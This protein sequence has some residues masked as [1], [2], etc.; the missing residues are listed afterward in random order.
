MINLGMILGRVGRLDAR[1]LGNGTKVV[2]L[3]LVTSKKLGKQSEKEEKI[4][5]HNVTLYNR[6]AEIVEAYVQ[7]GDLLWVQ[8][9]MDHQKYTAK[10]GTEKSKSF[11]LG[12]EIKLMPKNGAKPKQENFNTDTDIPF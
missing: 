12:H 9:E 7:V 6:L 5:W 10:D 1:T 3:S 2:N 8:G 11:I 4:T